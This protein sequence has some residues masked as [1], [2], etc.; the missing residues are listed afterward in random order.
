VVW[1]RNGRDAGTADAG[2]RGWRES[3]GWL[4]RRVCTAGDDREARR[5]KVLFTASM[6]AMLP[7][8]LFWPALYFAYGERGAAAIPFSYA[9]LTSVDFLILLRLRRFELFRNVQQFLI[10]ALPFGLQLA[11]GGFVAG[12]AVILWSLIAVLMAL[13]FG[14]PRTAVWWFVAYASEVVAAAA[15][16]PGLAVDNDLPHW[17]VTGL[18]T[19]NITTVSFISFAVLLSFVTDRRKLR[20]LEVAFLDQELALRQSEKM[21]TLGTLAAGVAHELNNPAAATRRASEQLRD[22]ISRFEL[23]HVSADVPPLTPEGRELLQSLER[24][25]LGRATGPGDLDA[26]ERSDRE[27]AVESWLDEHGV[28]DGRELAPS[29]VDQGLDLPALSKLADALEPEALAAVLVRAASAFPVHQL[30]HEIGEASGRV[31][32]IVAALKSY[33]FLGQAPIQAVDLHEGLDNTLVILRAKLKDGI[34]VHRDYGGDVL[35]VPAYGS[36]LNQVWTNLLD[37]AI[38]AM[39]GTG[40][41]TI[42]TR[43]DG[44]WAVVE[45]EDDGPGIP[46]AAKAQ[47]FDPFFT[48][49]EPGKGT[50]LGLSTSYSIVT[51]KHRGRISVESRPGLTRFTVCLPALPLGREGGS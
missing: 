25:A 29:L 47:I 45:I 33:S 3:V 30:L 22:A 15:L 51:E 4:E 36:E 39:N 17:L 19:L 10:L 13:L 28:A 14:G 6:I 27:T 34:D 5:H 21:A 1:R 11:L 41:I 20:A 42:R 8:L 24:S 31:S 23:A 38:D 18:F 49:K 16:Q 43:R 32:E 9:I 12:S 35:S 26:L 7:A 50:G 37:N 40:T 44:D 48:T 2:W 46:E